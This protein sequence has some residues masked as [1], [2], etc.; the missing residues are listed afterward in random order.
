MPVMTKTDP[1]L[2]SGLRLVVARLA[3][4]LRQQ[5]EGEVT[6]SMLSA[7]STSENH[8]PMTLGELAAYERI[9]PPTMTS[10]I[11]RLEEAGLVSRETDAKDRRISRI[12]IS[13]EGRRFLARSRSRKD[14]YLA[15][16]IGRLSEQEVATLLRAVPILEKL[17]EENPS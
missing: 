9:Q 15:K 16:R 11:S 14:A 8:G 3:R 6:P 2:V 10:I 4:R 5:A 1:K 12:T 17:L 13:A 7:L